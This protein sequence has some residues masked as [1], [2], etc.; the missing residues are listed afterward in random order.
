MRTV[1]HALD[2]FSKN[3]KIYQASSISFKI[4]NGSNWTH[5]YVLAFKIEYGVESVSFPTTVV[6]S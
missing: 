1:S 6:P 3:A 2:Y 4:E 5:A